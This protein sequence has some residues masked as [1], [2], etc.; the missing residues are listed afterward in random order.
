[1]SERK[2]AVIIQ[3]SSG[4][5]VEWLKLGMNRHLAYAEAHGFDTWFIFG[6][7][8]P[9]SLGRPV[10]WEKAHLIHQ[11]LLA[12]YETVI[13]MDSDVQIVGDED[14][15]NAV[16]AEGI[17]AVWH[18]MEEWGAPHCYDHWNVGVLYLR[19]SALVLSFVEAWLDVRH[20]GHEWFDQ[21][22]FNTLAKQPP[23]EGLIVEIDRR[24]HSTIPHHA[25]SDPNPVVVA[26]HGGGSIEARAKAMREYLQ[27]RGL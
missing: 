17:G 2:D 16:P 19:S 25:S 18:V 6:E 23:Y 14:L 24:W 26:W 15:R 7:A 12:G 8:R 27:E 4:P 3:Q 20:E 1:M 5:Y 13:A 22:A 10:N 11:A 9:L 21:H